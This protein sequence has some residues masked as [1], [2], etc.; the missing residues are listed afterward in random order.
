MWASGRNRLAAV[1]AIF[2]RLEGRA[3]QQIEVNNIT[4]ELREKPDEELK[5]YIDNGRWPEDPSNLRLAQRH[6]GTVTVEYNVFID[7][8]RE[9]RS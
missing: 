4:R 6:G 8:G 1:E 9:R 5:C 7:F 2:D 3:R